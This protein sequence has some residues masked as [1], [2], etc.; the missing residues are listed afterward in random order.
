MGTPQIKQAGGRHEQLFPTFPGFS[1]RGSETATPIFYFRLRASD[2]A[3]G[4]TLRLLNLGGL[5]NV[6]N[7]PNITLFDIHGRTVQ[8][9][10][11]P[12]AATTLELDTADLPAGMYFYE[13]R[14]AGR[15]L[16]AGKMVRRP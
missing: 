8:Q 10:I 4:N 13:L 5:V 14:D 12:K 6:T 2:F 15:V 7:A 9:T 1:N 3:M 16:A 11:W